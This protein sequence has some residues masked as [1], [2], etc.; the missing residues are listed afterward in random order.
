LGGEGGTRFHRKK[1]DVDLA[2]AREL[3]VF[4]DDFDAAGI[5]AGCARATAGDGFC[6]HRVV[7]R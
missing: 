1:R 3:V 7:V 5:S 2:A 6:G 4:G